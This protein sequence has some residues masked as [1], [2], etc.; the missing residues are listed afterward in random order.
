M[1][2]PHVMRI[3][4][5]TRLV[6][7]MKIKERLTEKLLKSAEEPFTVAGIPVGIN[8]HMLYMARTRVS[9]FPRSFLS[10]DRSSRSEI[11][12]SQDRIRTPIRPAKG[13]YLGGMSWD[14][15]SSTEY[16]PSLKSLVDSYTTNLTASAKEVGRLEQ[17]L[18]TLQSENEGM[19]GTF[20]Q[21]RSQHSEEKK[22][23]V[24]KMESARVRHEHETAEA[25]E[26]YRE[27][28][29]RVEFLK[30]RQKLE[31]SLCY[32]R[33]DA[34]TELR[35]AFLR[36]RAET[37]TKF[38]KEKEKLQVVFSRER[39]DAETELRAVLSRGRSDAEIEF[40]REKDELRAGLS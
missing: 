3:N 7:S 18:T 34:E 32:E 15:Q 2:E 25:E 13:R 19:R 23:L 21:A 37:K 6:N 17:Q 29:S 10:K 20:I 5:I 24:E 36:E 12:T 30:E 39:A 14:I 33:E 4:R 38:Q 28:G 31:V 35:D 8:E 40:Q 11:D 22:A 16:I 9:V 26:K 27:G 1:A